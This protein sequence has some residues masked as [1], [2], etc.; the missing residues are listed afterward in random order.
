MKKINSVCS[1]MLLLKQFLIFPTVT[2]LI[3]GF[4]F[5]ETAIC[6]TSCQILNFGI[7]Q[8][9]DIVEFEF[10]KSSSSLKS[11]MNKSLKKASYSHFPNQSKQRLNQ[12]K[13][14][15]KT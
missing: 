14:S 4:K 9:N 2:V 6:F 8:F 7:L 13:R 1:K 10:E 12:N 11:A 3:L 15:S 5:G